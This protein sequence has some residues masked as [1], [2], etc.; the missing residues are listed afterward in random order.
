MKKSFSCLS[1]IF[2]LLI[3]F[4]LIA[5]GGLIYYHF[6]IHPLAGVIW[7][8]L[9]IHLFG[10]QELASLVLSGVPFVIGL[11]SLARTITRVF[12]ARKNPARGRG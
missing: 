2:D 9:V 1:A 5:M 3:D 10:S 7:N 4:A 6:S 11:F 8:P 12:A